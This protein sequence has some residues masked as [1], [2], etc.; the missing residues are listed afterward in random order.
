MSSRDDQL[1]KLAIEWSQIAEAARAKAVELAEA[2]VPLAIVR[3]AR[4]AGRLADT[5][6]RNVDL[7][8][9]QTNGRD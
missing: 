6:F 8:A 2:G 7:Y 3:D 1:I 4:L 9:T 5:V